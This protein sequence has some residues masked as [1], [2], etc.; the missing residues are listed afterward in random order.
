MPLSRR[1]VLAA[2]PDGIPQAEHFRVE[3]HEPLAPKPGEVVVRNQFLS[4][5][6]AMRGWVSAVANYA[7]PVGIGEVMRS[8]ASGEVIASEHPGYR[9]GDKVTGM[10]GWQEVAVVPASAVSRKVTETDLPLSTSLGVLGLN[11]VTA[12]FGLLDVGCPKPGDTVLVSTAAGSVGSAV[13]QIA[14]L[15]GCRTVGIAGGAAKVRQCLDDFGYD[16]AIDYKATN[17]LAAAV[18]EACPRGVDVYFDNTSGAVSD[19]VLRTLAMGARVVICGTA[20]VASWDPWPAGPRPERH[21]LV[22]RARMQGVLAFDYAHRFPEALARLAGWV[23][24]GELRYAEDIL[25]GIAAAPD[26][27]ASLYRGENRG[28]RLIRLHG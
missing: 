15:M 23:R 5:E 14:R 4:V 19:A 18:A 28:K 27:I 26:A 16:A 24:S 25:E 9:P 20:S 10:F 7:E 8:F 3:A 2:R 6:P 12:Y 1:V 13:G 11:G 22:K 17:D 21:L